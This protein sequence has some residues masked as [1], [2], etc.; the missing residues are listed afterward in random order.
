M[1]KT[2][3]SILAI[4]VTSIL[5][6]QDL[7]FVKFPNQKHYYNEDAPY[8]N[9][10][11]DSLAIK[12]YDLTEYFINN[13]ASKGLSEYQYK[14]DGIKYFFLNEKN[15]LIFIHNPE[16]YLPQF[17]GYCASRMTSGINGGLPG[18]ESVSPEYYMIIDNKLYLFTKV[19]YILNFGNRIKRRI[20]KKQIEHG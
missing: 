10:D 4:F 8:Y 17:G 20:W 12:G 1:K 2:Y 13:K 6:A 18:K 7:I 11:K 19:S 16:K 3:L 14:Y 9:I 5:N 15:K